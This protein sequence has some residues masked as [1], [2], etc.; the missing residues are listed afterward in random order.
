M[1]KKQIEE[2]FSTEELI[3]VL[4]LEPGQSVIIFN[5]ARK[6]TTVVDHDCSKNFYYISGLARRC[7]EC[8]KIRYKE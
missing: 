5:E 8:G 2:V 6:E 4:K 1:K 7:S 3:D